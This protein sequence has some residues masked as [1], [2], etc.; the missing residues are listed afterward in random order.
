VLV[1]GVAVALLVRSWSSGRRRGEREE[2]LD[3]VLERRV[4]DELARFDG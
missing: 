1:G 3:P 2:P 4:D